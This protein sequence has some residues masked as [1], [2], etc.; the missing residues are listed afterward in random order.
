MDFKKIQNDVSVDFIM[1]FGVQEL[2]RL[3]PP[4]TYSEQTI[5]TGN[6]SG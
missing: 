1:K 4:L 2:P 3:A 6:Y 5:K